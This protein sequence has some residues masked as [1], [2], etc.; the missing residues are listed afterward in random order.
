[1]CGQWVASWQS[2]CWASPF[3]QVCLSLSFP[4][5]FFP[6]HSHYLLNVVQQNCCWASPSSQVCL[7]LSFP[8]LF[9]PSHSHYLFNV[10]HQNCCWASPSSQVCLSLPSLSFSFL[11]IL[12]T[13]SM[14]CNRAAAGQVHLPRSALFFPHLIHCFA[15]Y[16]PETNSRLPCL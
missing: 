16:I 5:L 11:P 7:F 3:S 6:S 2:C 10:V 4:V 13:C 12:T 8:V 14:L 15:P 9:F 1:M